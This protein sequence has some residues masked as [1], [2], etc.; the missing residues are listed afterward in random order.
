MG[1]PW[2]FWKELSGQN[3]IGVPL[4]LECLQPGDSVFTLIAPFDWVRPT[5]VHVSNEFILPIPGT[6]KFPSKTLA[7]PF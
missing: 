4:L 6:N 5:G 7:K 1:E 2:P 3:D